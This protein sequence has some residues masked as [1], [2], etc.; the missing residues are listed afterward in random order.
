MLGPEGPFCQRY[1]M[2][3]SKDPLRGGTNADGSRH[4]EYCSHCYVSGRFTEPNFS[5]EEMMR[6]PLG[7]AG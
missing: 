1:G 7:Q 4:S 5:M 2:P 3:L 6:A